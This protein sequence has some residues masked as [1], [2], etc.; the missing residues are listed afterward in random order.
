MVP[1]TFEIATCF[2]SILLRRSSVQKQFSLLTK[3]KVIMKVIQQKTE[4]L[5]DCFEV[6]SSLCSFAQ[7]EKKKILFKAPKTPLNPD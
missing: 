3:P 7:K 6:T 1:L 2:K 4:E 5:Q